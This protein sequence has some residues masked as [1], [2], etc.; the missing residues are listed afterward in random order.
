MCVIVAVPKGAQDISHQEFKR[1]ANYHDDGYGIAYQHKGRIKYWKTLK[2]GDKEA[3]F[4]PPKP[5]I[6]HFRM[7]T[8]GGED[9]KLCHPFVV[10][11]SSRPKKHGMADRV[12]F[13]NGHLHHWEELALA[14]YSS[15]GRLPKG[16][17]SDSRAVAMMLGRF[18]ENIFDI[19]GIISGQKY[20]LFENNG[21]FKLFGRGWVKGDDGVYRSNESHL[22]YHYGWADSAYDNIT[23]AEYDN[24]ND[25][26]SK[27]T[28]NSCFDCQGFLPA[29]NKTQLC[30]ECFVHR[31]DNGCYKC[32]TAI[33]SSMDAGFKYGLCNKCWGDETVYHTCQESHC[34]APL[35]TLN[36]KMI[37]YC[38]RC[39][40]QHKKGNKIKRCQS[41]NDVLEEGV[42]GRCE[43]CAEADEHFERQIARLVR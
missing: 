31:I 22:N 35:Y 2:P 36:S 9:A 8:V 41:C 6:M 38:V 24:Y 37:G 5:Y 7:A 43:L 17:Y 26:T 1:A 40:T 20:A 13:H 27:T 23:K 25:Y 14:A 32:G 3:D 30:H 42:T 33:L 28:A 39:R 12:M 15:I 4:R 11:H 21:D 19:D 18:G 34:T 10:D 16:P 29:G